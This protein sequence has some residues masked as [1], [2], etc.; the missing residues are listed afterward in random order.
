MFNLLKK[1][2]LVIIL[3]FVAGGLTCFPQI[4]AIKQVNNFQGVYRTVSNDE[5]YYL[6]R[7]KDIIDGHTFLS[8]PY[9][10]EYKNGYPTEVWLPEY[11]L[12][13][14]LALLNIDLHKGYLFY[15]FLLPS[16]LVILTYSILYLLT[17]SV[18]SSFL[19]AAF[20]H[21]NLF[22]FQF[23]RNPSPQFNFIF[24]LLLYLIW[25]KF[26]KKPT[27][28]YTIAMGAVFGL[29]FYIYTYYWTFYVVFFAI[30]LFLNFILKR[31]LPYKKYF[32]AFS[33]AFIISIPYFV[34]MIKDTGLP[35]YNETLA[36]I[37]MIDT[38]FPSGRKIVMWGLVIL[39]LLYASYK[40]RILSIGLRPILLLSGVLASI[41]VVNQHVITGK[42][43]FFASHYWM[44]SAFCFIFAFVYL[45][46]LWLNKIK[47]RYIK[48]ILLILISCYIFYRP[49]INAIATVRED[50]GYS[51]IEIGEQRYTPIFSWLNLNTQK[52]EVVFPDEELSSLIPVYT[53][54]NVFYNANAGLHFMSDE[55]LWR[56]FVLAH[57]WN[58]IDVKFA[59]DNI[60]YVRGYYYT[61][62]CDHNQSKNK[63]RKLFFLP[64]EACVKNS[65]G[66]IDKF[67]KLAQDVQ[68]RDFYPQLK[69]YKV[70]YFI[71]DKKND[72][73]WPV[74]DLKFL[75]PVYEANDIAVYK[76]K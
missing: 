73:N 63:I 35:Y 26:L 76:V 17:G 74:N 3:A 56:R 43:M 59:Q 5:A 72:L 61:A 58:K 1:H 41:I 70:D 29:L 18:F 52:D 53:A 20:L 15:D 16:I 57:Y 23:N 27:L 66:E 42:N 10:Y 34:F 24:W 62:L 36:R 22:L 2:Y 64:P 65:S 55:D 13:K 68:S 38:H 31:P 69:K 46:N 44:L 51:Q 12:A 19:G 14:P 48:I 6:A 40:K 8:N 71:W 37:G 50:T 47:I 60:F 45:L 25:L 4:F 11:I 39:L 9:L 32:L 33:I 67:L 75:E 28:F 7:A 49:V 30:F 21:L 54:D